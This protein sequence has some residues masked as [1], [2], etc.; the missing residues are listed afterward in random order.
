MS[1][2]DWSIFSCPSF[3]V[4]NSITSASLNC[5]ATYKCAAYMKY[6]EPSL[7]LQY[8]FILPFEGVITAVSIKRNNKSL[9]CNGIPSEDGIIQR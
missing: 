5:I 3:L 8:V 2:P 1:G 9:G 4:T 6:G 7:T